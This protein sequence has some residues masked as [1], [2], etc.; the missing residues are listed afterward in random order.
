[1]ASD[2][3]RTPVPVYREEPMRWIHAAGRGLLVLLVVMTGYAAS[4]VGGILI[5][6]VLG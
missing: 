4:G 5:V 1:M 3:A 2:R 6:A